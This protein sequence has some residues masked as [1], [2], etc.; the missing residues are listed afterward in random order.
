M[1][2]L[3]AVAKHSLEMAEKIAE[4]GG[5][6]AFLICAENVDVLVCCKI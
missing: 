1:Q 5:L 2:A 6:S 4:I 3:K